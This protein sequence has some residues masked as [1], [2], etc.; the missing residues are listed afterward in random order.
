MIFD[1]NNF[2]VALR[3]NFRALQASS[4][5]VHH[6]LLALRVVDAFDVTMS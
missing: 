5:F 2:L 6:N 3:H 1:K 4:I